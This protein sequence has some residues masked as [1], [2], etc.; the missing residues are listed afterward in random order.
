MLLFPQGRILVFCKAPEPGKVKTRLQSALSPEQC[1]ELHAQLARH[2]LQTA[3]DSGL[4]EIELWCAGDIEHP[5]FKEC[6][7][8]YGLGLRRQQ[9]ADLGAR[10]AH[11]LQATL[12]SSAFGIIIGT[13]CPDLDKIHLQSAAEFLAA[14]NTAPGT[15]RVVV[16]PATDGG[17]VLFGADHAVNGA[18]ENIDW[19]GSRVLQQT[20]ARLQSM[21]V[22][23]RELE[24]LADI[25]QP[26][27]L[28][29][30]PA[31]LASRLFIP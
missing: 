26:E 21:R 28:T 9:G 3:V 25:D 24:P 12:R 31:E 14:K 6:V 18:F 15:A 5:F 11:A 13:D 22:V 23:C 19:G 7:R 16:G 30:L 2:T 27:D 8:N 29:Y 10:M 17:Y 1:A 20:R 4:A